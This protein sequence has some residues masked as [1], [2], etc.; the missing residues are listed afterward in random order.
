[1]NTQPTPALT[2]IVCT[3][4][5]RADCI[6]ETLDSLRNLAAP[7]DGSAWELIVVDNASREPLEG[8]LDLSWHPDARVVREDRLGL[9]H[10]RVRSFREA[11]GEILLYVDDDNILGTQYLLEVIAAFAANPQ[12]GAVGGRVLPRY[13][14]DPPAWFHEGGFSLACRD[15][16]DEPIVA[17]WDEKSDRAYPECAPIGAGMALRREAYGAYVDA[18]SCDPVRLA[19][20]R[21]GTDLASGEDNVMILT[22]LGKGW[23]VAYLPQLHIDHIIPAARLTEAYMTRYAASSNRTWVIV[24]GLHGIRPWQPIARWTLPAR[25]ARAWLV[26]SAWRGPLDRIAWAGSCGLFDGQAALAEIAA[27]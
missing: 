22:I 14:V 9:S 6:G 18:A 27:P 8:R 10:A 20:G 17:R 11:R 23:D 26:Q 1:M 24:L 12:L 25:K 4:N 21:K 19:L 3:H 13:E 16:G 5:P 2:V 15:L 7:V